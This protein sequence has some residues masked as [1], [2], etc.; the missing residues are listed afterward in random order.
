MNEALSF[1]K[2]QNKIW[3]I[4]GWNYPIDVSRLEDVLLWRFMTCGGWATWSDR[5][6]HYEKNVDKTI[7]DFSKKDINYLNLDNY[8]KM[9]GL[10]L[11]QI[12]KK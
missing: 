10:R 6:K 5:W 7:K 8:E 12:R 2:Y 1:Y 4:S 9:P 11:L 3:H